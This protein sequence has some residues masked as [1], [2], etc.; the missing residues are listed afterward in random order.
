VLDGGGNALANVG[1]AFSVTSGPNVGA[2][3]TAITDPAGHASFTY[4]DTS[5]GTD[6]V[7]A[8]VTTVGSFNAQ[9]MVQWGATSPSWTGAD[10]GNPP[11]AGSDSFA[12]GVWTISGNGRDIGGTTDQFHFVSQPVPGDTSL[13]A[14]VVT[15]TNTNSRARAGVMFRQSVDPASPFYAA[16]VTPSS[17]VWVLERP[18]FGAGVV[19]LLTTPG[20][21]PVYLR[22]DRTGQSATAS[23]S[24]D[25]TTWTPLAGSA[26][27]FAVNG[28]VLAGLAVT[29]HSLT[30]L[31]TATFDHVNLSGS[32]PPPASNDFSISANPTGVGVVAGNSGTTSINTA[33]VS[34]SA[35]SISLGASGLP[36]G[37]TAGFNPAS[38]NTGGASTLTFTVG[39]GTA[40]GTYP[41]TVT[42]TAASA[43][44][45]T[46]VSLTVS[47][48][49]SLPSPWLDTDV[50]APSPAGSA[51]YAGG[52]FTVNGAGA[53]IFGTSDQFNYLYQN[54][55]GN[56]TF[57]ARV[58]SETNAGSTNDKAGVMWKASTTAGSPYILI[59]AAPSGLVKVQYNFSGSISTSTYAFP[60]VWMKLV[61]SGSSFSAFLSPDGVT[62]TSVLA[63]KTLTTIPTAATVGLFECSHSTTKLGTAT[64]DNVSFTP[65]P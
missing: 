63:N 62:W 43:T 7:A 17:G 30:A 60:N 20:T 4:A 24:A 6:V 29:S 3:G 1:V 19:T 57:I 5:A 59:A 37:V 47:A 38:V 26:A 36:S 58:A 23:T 31:G 28:A 16:I 14:R 22:V 40:P 35:E 21:V 45:S 52:V 27:T 50:G 2:I 9:S 44:H 12:G 25:G 46:S 54:T 64:F 51:A 42:G 13:S 53:D 49:G 33:I 56:G 41:V 48:P 55:A 61:R 39:S 11:I 8:S 32:V 15:Q 65:G 34:G 10:I 18:T